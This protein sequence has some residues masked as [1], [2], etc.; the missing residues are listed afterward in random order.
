MFSIARAL[1]LIGTTTVWG[2]SGYATQRPTMPVALVVN[3]DSEKA[4]NAT[5]SF[6]SK[7][8]RELGDVSVV[9]ISDPHA[10][11]VQVVIIEMQNSAGVFDG[12]AMSTVLTSRLPTLAAI[13]SQPIDAESKKKISSIAFANEPFE[14]NVIN[15]VPPSLSG[16]EEAIKTAVIHLDGAVIEQ[17]RQ[18]FEQMASSV[19]AAFPNAH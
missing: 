16:L 4:R 6:F 11:T 10:M 9:K 17:Q 14:T 8:L 2:T 13:A 12:Y 5:I 15:V 3:C 19:T 18:L 1:L 7:S